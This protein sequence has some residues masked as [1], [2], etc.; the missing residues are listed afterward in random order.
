L[1]Y[2][3]LVGLGKPPLVARQGSPVKG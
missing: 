2:Q 1:A 3:V